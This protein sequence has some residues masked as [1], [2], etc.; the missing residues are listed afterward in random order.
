MN[1]IR[2]RNSAWPA[3]LAAF[4]LSS[5]LAAIPAAFAAVA[6]SWDT[7]WL[8]E[9]LAATPPEQTLVQ[10]GDMQLLTDRLRAQQNLVVGGSTTNT[11]AADGLAPLW[12]S[13]TVYYTFDASVS[14]AK[15]KAFLDGAAEWAMFANLRFLPRTSQANYLTVREIPGL[16]GGQSA[17]GMIGGQQFIDFGPGAWTRSVICH[18]IGHALGAIHEHQRSDRDS[19]VT[20][21]TNNIQ[22]GLEANFIRLGNSTNLGA[23]DFLSVM[24]YRRDAYS[25]TPDTLNTIVPL[26]AY[27]TFLNLIGVQFDQVLS[28]GDRAGMAARYGAGPTLGSVVT[29]TLDS[30]PG[31]LRAAL[32]YAL[33]HPGTTITFNIPTS[34]PGFGGGV[35]TIRPT[36][37]FPALLRGTTL[38]GSSQPGNSN[39][40]GPE[41]VL[42]GALCDPTY[43][44]SDGL[45][46]TGTNCVVQSLVIN[47]FPGS[48]IVIDGTNATGNA[49]RGCYLNLN[50]T[51][52]A[53]ST[54]RYDGLVIS[55][56]ASGNVIGGTNATARN[57]ISGGAFGG[58]IIR[59][60]GTRSNT[61]AGNYIGVN[62]AGTAAVPNA[63]A[64]LLIYNGATF[65]VI[66]GTTAGAGNVIS[67]NGYEGLG[68]ADV[69]TSGNSVQGN[70]IGL[71]ATGTAA[72]SNTW[73]GLS[74]FNGASSNLIG[75]TSAAARNVISGNGQQ[76]LALVDTN[77]SGNRIVGNFIGLNAAGT[78]AV[79][80]RWSGVQLYGGPN[81]TTIGG[82]TAAERNVI[83]GNS[84]QGVYLS[85][86]STRNNSILGN[87]I[88]TTPDGSAPLPNGWTGVDLGGAATNFIGGATPGA[89][90]VISGNGNYGV[91]ITGNGNGNVVAGNLIGLDA[92]G[93]IG[94]P[95]TWSGVRLG[96]A[97]G[98]LIGG[99]TSGAGNTISG[100]ANYGVEL[101]ASGASSNRIQGNRIGLNAAGTAPL[102]NN[103]DGVSLYSGANG[104]I[105]GLAADG[106]GAGNDIANNSG[107]GIVLFDAGTTNNSLRGNNVTANGFLGI[108]LSGGT[109]GGWGVTFN[110][111]DDTDSGP[112]QLQN[113]PVLTQAS[114]SGTHTLVGGTFNGTANR[115]VLIDLYRND[116]P[117]LSSYGE[118]QRY[119]GSSSVTTDGS[120]AATFSLVLSGNYSGQHFTATATD[121]ATGNTSEFALSLLATNGPALPEFTG[122]PQL[123]R[124]GFVAQLLVNVGQSYRV[125]ATTNLAPPLLWT[126]VTNFTAT[127]TN[128]I[129]LDRSAT[130][131]PQR[132]YRIVTP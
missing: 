50:A 119:V 6:P 51:G 7:R 3:T 36:D 80:N 123:T 18:E 26:P 9:L 8:N 98:N 110:D 93:S 101:S 128:Y 47:G 17:V 103:W 60:P 127:V 35:F 131:A 41:I 37:N 114:G 75:G 113:F 130:N 19:Y 12:S 85:D 59:N 71:N 108:N 116:A 46:L 52:T 99:T 2:P 125:E 79:P 29:N 32:Y 115:T 77:T 56:G 90:N 34:D 105:I 39:P 42:N 102:G 118:G 64:G 31:S 117:D 57:V 78:A 45:R 48:G 120:G 38:D 53:A 5:Y 15:Q 16:G 10:I 126:S 20:I 23:Y 33:D 121:A 104:N 21:L 81:H 66:G 13:G 109:E 1:V 49:V 106:S 14:A 68:I 112:N 25:T 43:I 82:V 107:Y 69:G 84:F 111:G 30:G 74:I 94:I 89:G 58:V 124:T 86:P 67:G 87:Y 61:V 28:P 96:D 55:G 122:A 70:L 83:S 73:Q 62:A 91:T 88:G 63:Q 65:N 11:L 97:R 132:F 27:A 72:I 95:N 40:S 92:S 54:N 4:L 22:P 100:N 44:Y 76:G 24:H 129:F